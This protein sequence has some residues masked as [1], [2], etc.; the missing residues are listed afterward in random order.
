[1]VQPGE[2]NRRHRPVEK[3]AVTEMVPPSF[4]FRSFWWKGELV[5]FGPYWNTVADYAITR[6]EERSAI[7][8]A[9]QV[10][11]RVAVPFL[12]VD[13][14]QKADGQWVLIEC[15]DGQESGYAG[16]SALSMWQKIIDIERGR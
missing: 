1:M 6:S 15:N 4:E 9:R 5:G 14:A 16:I 12:V 7:S 3:I 10:A 8:L 2:R 11:S 13:I